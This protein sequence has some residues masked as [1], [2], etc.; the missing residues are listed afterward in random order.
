[1]LDYGA[2][3]DIPDV[4]GQTPL[5]VAVKNGHHACARLLLERGADPNG[6]GNNRSTPLS[7]AAMQGSVELVQVSSSSFFLLPFSRPSSILSITSRDQTGYT[8]HAGFCLFPQSCDL[9][10]E[11]AGSL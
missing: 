7:L 3:I 6:N 2:S 8:V 4:K 11:T 9:R 10:T 5:H 1:L